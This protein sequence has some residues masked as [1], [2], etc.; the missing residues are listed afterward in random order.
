MTTYAIRSDQD[1]DQALRAVKNRQM[2]CTVQITNGAPRSI[3]QNKLQRLWLNELAEQDD[4]M[5][6]EEYR[7]WCKA[8][9]GIPILVHENEVFREEYNRVIKPLSYELK[10]RLMMVP[11][12]FGVTR[13]MTT[14]QKKDY[15]DKM[16]THFTELGF[17]LTDPDRRGTES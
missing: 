6:A 16:H 14:K 2:P 3:E 11:F 9:I 1:R 12:D 7:G 15:L 8:H 17:Q 10:M 4:N 13:L 5:T